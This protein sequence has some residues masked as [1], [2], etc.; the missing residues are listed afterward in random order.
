MKQKY[1]RVNLWRHR[2]G[3]GI[4]ETC[5]YGYKSISS[6]AY[7]QRMIVRRLWGPKK[8]QF[9]TIH[10]GTIDDIEECHGGQVARIMPAHLNWIMAR[11][12]RVANSTQ[13]HAG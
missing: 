12:S 11:S 2:P 1:S 3:A 9:H 6:R 13:V 4:P 5:S 10:D 7:A 8:S